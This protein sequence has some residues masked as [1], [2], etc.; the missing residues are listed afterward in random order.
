MYCTGG[1]RCEKASAYMLARGFE[2]VFHLQGGILKYLEEVPEAE[3]KWRGD[4][5]VF[6]KRVAVGP[7]LREAEWS[8][9]FGC[10]APLCA[11]DR[12]RDDYEE[13]VCCLHCVDRLTPEHA[14][15]LRMR[16]RQMAER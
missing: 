5:F 2:R 11:E 12:Q 7:A 10:R 13:G 16:H 6:D 8:M 14:A 9:C 4:C 3:S 1:I 15:S